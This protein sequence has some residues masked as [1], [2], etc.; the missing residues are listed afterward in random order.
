MTIAA[1]LLQEFPA[2]SEAQ[3]AVVAHGEGPL[4]VIAGPGSELA[5][6]TLSEQKQ[7]DRSQDEAVRHHPSAYRGTSSNGI[8]RVRGTS[9]CYVPS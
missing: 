6:Q 7:V 5:G 8:R 1:E 4:L 2:M 3:R 9:P